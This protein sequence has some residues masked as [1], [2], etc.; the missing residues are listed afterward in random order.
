[1][2]PYSGLIWS[3]SHFTWMDTNYPAGTPREG[4]PVEIQ[5]LWIRLLRQLRRISGQPERRRWRELAEQAQA[6]LQKYFWLE[7]RGYFADLLVAKKGQPAPDA[8][9]DDC[10]AQQ[11]SVRGES[12]SGH[13]RARPGVAWMRR[14]AIWSCPGRCARWRRCPFRRRC[15]SMGIMANC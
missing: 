7:E 9:V 12:R 8:V 14:C 3:P 13:R 6:S 1:M 10:A 5:V 4:Y 15:P 11:L 2:D